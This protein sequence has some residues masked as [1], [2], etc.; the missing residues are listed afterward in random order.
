MDAETIAQGLG[1]RRYGNSWR[2]VCPVCGNTNEHKFKIS[3]GDKRPLVHC[4]AGCDFRTIVAELESRGLWEKSERP[5]GPPPKKVEWARWCVAIFEEAK[6][7]G[8]E[9][10][11]HDWRDYR[12]AQAVLREVDGG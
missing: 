7:T 1:A 4:F 9:L 8:Q 11:A 2:C 3:E 10:A 12:K 5:P 6:R